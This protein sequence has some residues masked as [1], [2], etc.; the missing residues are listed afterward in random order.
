MLDRFKHWIVRLNA[1]LGVL[2]GVL[3]IGLILSVV[4]DLV[5]RT[6][7][8]TAIYGASETSILLLVV[9]VFLGLA[10]AQVRKEH[11]HVGVLDSVLSDRA[12]RLLTVFRYIVSAG[13]AGGFAWYSARGA[14]FST[15]RF[16]ES[17][18]VIAYPVWPARIIVA[19]GFTLLTVQCLLDARDAVRGELH[20]GAPGT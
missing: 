2:A 8:N 7:F 17:Y 4:P 1:S 5:A 14:W 11:Y 18:A 13:I 16:E 12:L 6:F 3:V 15:L 19:V 10:A 9:I 20:R